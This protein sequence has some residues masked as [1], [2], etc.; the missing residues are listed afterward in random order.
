LP[1]HQREQARQ[2]NVEIIEMKDFKT[3]FIQKLK[4]RALHLRM[5]SR[6]PNLKK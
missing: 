2:F 6:I 3:D 1:Q 5:E 4:L